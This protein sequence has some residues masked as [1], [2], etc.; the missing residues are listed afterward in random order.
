MARMVLI[1]GDDISIKNPLIL[2]T[3]QK[4]DILGEFFQKLTLD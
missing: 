1:H 3:M 4:T 2:R